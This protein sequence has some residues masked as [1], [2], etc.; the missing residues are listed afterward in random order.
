MGSRLVAN[1][2][3]DVAGQGFSPPTRPS[4]AAGGA[5]SPRCCALEGGPVGIRSN[6]VNPDAV[7]RDSKLWSD[8]V[9][10]ERARPG[11]QRG[12]PEDFYRQ[13]NI[14]AR[15]ILPEDV[16]ESFASPPTAPRRP[17]AALTRRRRRR[18]GRLPALTDMRMLGELQ[19]Q[20]RR[21]DTMRRAQP[22]AR[23]RISWRAQPQARE[24]N[25]GAFLHAFAEAQGL[26]AWRS[27]A[28]TPCGR[29]SRLPSIT[30]STSRSPLLASYASVT[31]RIRLRTAACISARLCAVPASPPRS[32]PPSTPQVGRAG[33]IGGGRGRRE[34]QGVR[35]LR[36]AAP[37]ARRPASPRASEVVRTLPARFPS[38]PRGRFTSFEA[39]SLLTPSSSRSP[40]ALRRS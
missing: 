8:E 20:A 4:K 6:I 32:R 11:H 34:P 31:H 38:S 7:F 16:A 13:R 17:P 40:R 2:E 18:E 33:W 30:R 1:Q 15:P 37:R 19:P 5:A 24:R 35:G 27:S 12:R 25:F 22:Q 14:L 10:R 23:E 28:T 26:G 9:R 39:V 3:R 21:A 36:S 29:G